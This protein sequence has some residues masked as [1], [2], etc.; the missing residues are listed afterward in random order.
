M[1]EFTNLFDNYDEPLST[2]LSQTFYD[3]LDEVC[4]AITPNGNN[5]KADTAEAETPFKSMSNAMVKVRIVPDTKFNYS[6]D[7]E[8]T[9]VDKM[10]DIDSAIAE[11]FDN[12]A[13]MMNNKQ[14]KGKTC[15]IH[16]VFTLPD[17]SAVT[18]VFFWD[19][20]NLA[21]YGWMNT[22]NPTDLK[23]LKY[24]ETE[25][26]FMPVYKSELSDYM[27]TIIV[28]V[29]EKP[30]APEIESPGS[31]DL[32]DDYEDLPVDCDKNSSENAESSEVPEEPNDVTDEDEGYDCYDPEVDPFAQ[33]TYQWQ[34]AESLY[35]KIND[36]IQ[37]K[38]VDKKL[39][40]ALTEATDRL[41]DASEFE[42]VRSINEVT[43]MPEVKEITFKLNDIILHSPDTI[44]TYDVWH[45]IKLKDYV[46]LLKKR[47]HFPKVYIV[48]STDNELVAY[49]FL[50]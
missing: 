13:I 50:K 42:V 40:D 7:I 36:D 47:Y 28:P 24:D 10:H 14:M 34:T 1:K 9:I 19:P 38:A 46:N 35:K 5:A 18:F 45:T 6:I 4:E 11:I 41:L 44:V 2:S 43:K 37:F 29:H 32:S 25:H 22:L 48:D 49:C 12:Y 23:C 30:I 20:K 27:K 8:S 16:I 15:K 33:D 31:E 21:F 39:W 17:T 26:G 3:L